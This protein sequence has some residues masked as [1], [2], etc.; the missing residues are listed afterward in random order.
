MGQS[1]IRGSDDGILTSPA[2]PLP[3]FALASPAAGGCLSASAIAV[4]GRRLRLGGCR[5]SLARGDRADRHRRRCREFLRP[6]A[7][8]VAL[9]DERHHGAGLVF[10]ERRPAWRHRLR[11]E[12]VELLRRAS[13]PFVHEVRA[14]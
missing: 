8:A 12:R 1:I 13:A 7:R 5:S 10:A 9:K 6:G 14:G 11:D 4:S 3:F 2:P